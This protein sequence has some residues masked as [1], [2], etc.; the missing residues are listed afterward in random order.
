MA[1][2]RQVNLGACLIRTRLYPIFSTGLGLVALGPAWNLG[3]L[4]YPRGMPMIN[5]WP[6]PDRITVWQECPIGQLGHDTRD[7][8][9]YVYGRQG[10][11]YAWSR[12]VRFKETP[13]TILLGLTSRPAKAKQKGPGC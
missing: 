4:R 2:P 10:N 5:F 3:Q 12:I 7:G 8:T 13:A 1:R 9:W 11:V 6:S